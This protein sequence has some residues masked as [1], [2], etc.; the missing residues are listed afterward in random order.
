MAKWVLV[1]TEIK[2]PFGEEDLVF[3]NGVGLVLG[4]RDSRDIRDDAPISEV[5]ARQEAI[6]LRLAP[7]DAE[8][9]QVYSGRGTMFRASSVGGGVVYA[10]R[11][12]FPRDGSRL[13]FIEK[14]TDMGATW[15]PLPPLP[16]GVIGFRFAVGGRGWIWTARTVLSTADDGHS[17]HEI[18]RLA[19]ERLF[20]KEA[21]PVF[22][23]DGAVWVPDGT[24]VLRVAGEKKDEFRLPNLEKADW[25]TL[26]P[27]GSVWLVGRFGE[28]GPA[29]VYRLE[30]G[31]EPELLSEI[32]IPH[33]LPLRL[34]V[35]REVALLAGA[36][37]GPGD[38]PPV[39][40]MLVSRDGGR[41]WTK[42]MPAVK[43]TLQPIYFETGEVVWAYANFG[44]IQK[45]MPK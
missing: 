33:Y 27:D 5:M 14:S 45:R 39:H 17:W 19:E 25:L 26:A 9:H 30:V 35:G 16:R 42:E 8:W 36:D 32:G 6:I 18:L 37:V 29:R 15:R 4:Y 7:G 40:F 28:A 34:H 24:R 11:E 10:L 1:S 43:A 3:E 44:R 2:E 23:P 22:E 13:Q 38:R 31:R 21:E 20:K 41:T 12:D